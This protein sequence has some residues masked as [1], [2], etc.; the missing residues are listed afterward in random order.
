MVS[1]RR[2]F[3]DWCYVG[4]EI[5]NSPVAIPPIDPQTYHTN[6]VSWWPPNF[7][8]PDS[9]DSYQDPNYCGLS[10][11]IDPADGEPKYEMCLLARLNR[12]KT[13]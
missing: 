9:I 7:V 4:E 11:E 3:G 6:W 5:P 13:L 10:T 1:T 12:S 8:A 2:T